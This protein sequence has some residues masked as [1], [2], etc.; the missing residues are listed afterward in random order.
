MESIPWLNNGFIIRKSIIEFLKKEFALLEVKSIPFFDKNT[1]H[2][3]LIP[4]HSKY[5]IPYY[6]ILT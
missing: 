3:K 2:K 1:L 6:V 4:F 5:E